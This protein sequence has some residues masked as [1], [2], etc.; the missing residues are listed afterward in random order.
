MIYLFFKPKLHFS[1]FL[2]HHWKSFMRTTF[3]IDISYELFRERLHPN[4]FSPL[5]H[6]AYRPKAILSTDSPSS[7]RR[8][9]MS[10][11]WVRSR[12]PSQV[13]PCCGWW[14]GS[15]IGALFIVES[16]YSI[17]YCRSL[18]VDIYR[19]TLIV[20]IMRIR[21]IRVPTLFEMNFLRTF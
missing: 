5:S 17:P 6:V 11:I 19:Y 13:C 8:N 18:F 15:C 10:M 12:V 16:V 9:T 7:V 2:K 21:W 4:L 20:L 1:V 3:E 14:V